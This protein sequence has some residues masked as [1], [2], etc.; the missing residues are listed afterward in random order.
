[1]G[2]VYIPMAKATKRVWVG[3]WTDPLALVEAG[4]PLIGGFS[5]DEDEQGNS[6][7]QHQ[8]AMVRGEV[9]LCIARAGGLRYLKYTWHGTNV[10]FVNLI[11]FVLWVVAEG[12]VLAPPLSL[13]LLATIPLSYFIGMAVAS[14]SAQSS[15]AVGA[16]LNATFGSIIEITLY[17]LALHNGKHELVEGAMRF[18][19]KSAGVSNTMLIMTLIGGFTPT[20]STKSLA[21]YVFIQSCCSYRAQDKADNLA[22]FT[23][24]DYH[25]K[26]IYHAPTPVS[27]PPSAPVSHSVPTSTGTVHRLPSTP[28]NQQHHH[29]H[30]PAQ[31]H[32]QNPH[33]VLMPASF[34]PPGSYASL[35]TPGSPTMTLSLPAAAMS[36]ST[37]TATNS[38]SHPMTPRRPRP[39]MSPMTTTS[40]MAT[41]GGRWPRSPEWSRGTSMFV[42]ISCTI[43]FALI[44]ELLV[45]TIEA[46]L[47]SVPWIPEKFLGVTLVALVP[48]LTEFVNAAAFALQ[49]NISLSL[50]IGSAYAVQVALIQIPALV[51]YSVISE[52][53]GIVPK[54]GLGGG[55][56]MLAL[57]FPSW[58]FVCVFLS[59][60]LLSYVYMEGNSNYFK[61]AILTAAYTVLIAA[62][63]FASI[64]PVHAPLSQSFVKFSAFS[65]ALSSSTAFHRLDEL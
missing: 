12:Y 46:V 34:M 61:G 13:C 43:T 41:V 65:P 40:T 20:C 10:M 32:G 1:M 24:V 3:M 63:Y 36:H 37:S 54:G 21:V 4:R 52:Y 18:N 50:E 19:A 9:V 26:H 44:A 47:H 22:A 58:D 38:R 6:A 23:R 56:R 48:S 57:I 14:I 28:P 39:R 25:K 35:A 29:H 15:P 60:F 49:G 16:V 45:D 27:A 51:W 2:V 59:V 64:L 30:N 55:S 33:S 53:L 5:S 17:S 7:R 11:P 62:F 31:H 42:L 8:P